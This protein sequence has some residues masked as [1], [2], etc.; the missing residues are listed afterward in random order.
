MADSKVVAFNVG[1][2]VYEVR[3]SLLD[4]FPNTLLARAASEVWQSS[5]NDTGEGGDT[6]I[7]SVKPISIERDGERFRYCLDYM[8]DGKVRLPLTE[9]KAALL[10]ELQYYGF[11]DVDGNSIDS[12]S[13]SSHLIEALESLAEYGKQGF[14]QSEA[15]KNAIEKVDKVARYARQAYLLSSPFRRDEEMNEKVVY[16]ETFYRN[17]GPRGTVRYTPQDQHRYWI[18]LDETLLDECLE[19]YGLRIESFVRELHGHHHFV[20]KLKRITQYKP[21][22]SHA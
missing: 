12:I 7:Y 3:R 19:P 17:S 16:D 11:E 6:R 1:G 15:W 9:S 10:H 18:T 13:P 2:R 20:L 21:P 22:S 4:S 5:D 8:R 14:E